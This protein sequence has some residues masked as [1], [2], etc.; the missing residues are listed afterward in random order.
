MSLRRAGLLT[1]LLLTVTPAAASAA[2]LVAPDGCGDAD[3]RVVRALGSSFAAGADP[4]HDI[5]RTVVQPVPGGVRVDVVLCADVPPVSF[6]SR[7]WRVDL[8]TSADEQLTLD[9]NDF[10]GLRKVFVAR[11]AGDRSIA[12]QRYDAGT[13]GRTIS[14]LLRRD[15]LVPEVAAA[16][17]PG[18]AVGRPVTRTS[19]LRTSV[20]RRE[21]ADVATPGTTDEAAGDGAVAVG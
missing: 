5:D 6:V 7:S 21:E 9:L 16:I 19:D 12:E 20:V 10:E 2:P 3:S 18:I 8:A 15:L 13:Q 1:T 4:A 11:A 17:A 14:F